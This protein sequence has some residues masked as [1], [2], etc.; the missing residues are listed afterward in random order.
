MK[1]QPGHVLI[2]S[3]DTTG[4]TL[5]IPRPS[6]GFHEPTV[7]WAVAV[8]APDGQECMLQFTKLFFIESKRLF[9]Q[10]E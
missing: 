4:V 2:S 3:Y 10:V 7:Q 1:C 6:M 8:L 5:N 9:F